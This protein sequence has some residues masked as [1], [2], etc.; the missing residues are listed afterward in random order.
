MVP[1]A[2]PRVVE[3]EPFVD[4]ER[5]ARFVGAP[6]RLVERVVAFEAAIGLHPVEDVVAAR[7]AEAAANVAHTDVRV[8]HH[9]M[10]P[11]RMRQC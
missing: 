9:F 4:D 10:V 8:G 2:G 3:P 1:D 11:R 7:A 5:L 6:E